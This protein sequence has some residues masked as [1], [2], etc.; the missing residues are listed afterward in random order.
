MGVSSV[1]RAW[2]IRQ[3][4]IFEEGGK[5]I[6]VISEKPRRLSERVQLATSPPVEIV[7]PPAATAWAGFD[8]RACT[9]ECLRFFMQHVIN[10]PRLSTTSAYNVHG[11]FLHVSGL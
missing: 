11:L 7:R 3:R 9:I 5:A 4:H 6:E 2:S 10:V 1:L 8:K